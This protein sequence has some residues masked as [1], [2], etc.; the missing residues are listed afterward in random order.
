MTALSEV[1]VD[2]SVFVAS[3][4]PEENDHKE[5]LAGMAIIRDQGVVLYEPAV[6]LFEVVGALHRKVKLGELKKE[7]A[8]LGIDLFFE[9]PMLLQW[10]ADLLKSATRI[11]S[12]MSYQHLYDSTY[13]AVAKVKKIPLLTLDKELIRRAKSLCAVGRPSDFL[14][15]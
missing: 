7:E 8:D 10:K 2:A 6:V 14:A 9:L 1:C 4:V 15:A 12:E 13:L 3:L 5:A 11:S